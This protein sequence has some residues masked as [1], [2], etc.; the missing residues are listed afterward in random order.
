MAVAVAAIMKFLRFIARS[1]ERS[2]AARREIDDHP[3]TSINADAAKT[4]VTPTVL[5]GIEPCPRDWPAWYARAMGATRDRGG[6]DARAR[7]EWDVCHE[8][9]RRRQPK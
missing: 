1:P 8:L 5:L 6:A 7:R 9:L 4:C 3:P 2:T